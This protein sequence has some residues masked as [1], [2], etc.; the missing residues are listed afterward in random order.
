MY[1]TNT[2]TV[3]SEFEVVSFV[4][5]SMNYVLIHRV[6]GHITHKHDT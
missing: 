4:I 2:I 3:L 6:E 5:K 1:Q